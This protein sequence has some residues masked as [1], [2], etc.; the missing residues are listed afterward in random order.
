MAR[1]DLNEA[2]SVKAAGGSDF[3]LA[4]ALKNKGYVKIDDFRRAID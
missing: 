4:E 1:S 2:F 3:D